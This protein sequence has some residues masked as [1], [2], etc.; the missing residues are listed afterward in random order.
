[1]RL[2]P[3]NTDLTDP[4]VRPFL[5]WHAEQCRRL[6][7]RAGL[8]G[9]HRGNTKG[10]TLLLSRHWPH[11]LCWQWTLDYNRSGWSGDALRSLA[12]TLRTPRAERWRERSAPAVVWDA[13]KPLL[14]YWEPNGWITFRLPFL[15]SLGLKWQDYD[16]MATSGPLG[17][18]AQR[19]D[20]SAYHA[21][22][23]ARSAFSSG[24]WQPEHDA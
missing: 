23:A 24:R 22:Q 2:F 8:K 10:R 5:A 13:C 21:R 18:D 3:S 19:I 7:W 1:M 14:I 6:G 12:E 11:L 16:L 15:G 17:R 4:S 9:P 20:W